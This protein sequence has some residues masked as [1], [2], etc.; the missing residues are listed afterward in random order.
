[1][2]VGTSQE[3]GRRIKL[4]LG[5]TITTGN[6]TILNEGIVNVNKTVGAATQITLPRKPEKEDVILIKD[7]KGDAGTNAITIL[8]DGT[9][10]TT[11]DGAASYL[12][13]AN[14]GSV[15]LGFNGTEWNALGSFKSGDGI[16][17]SAAGVA[18]HD[19][20]SEAV[21]ASYTIPANTIKAGTTITVRGRLT[22]TATVG[23]DT[24][25]FL[26]RLGTTTL[27]GTALITGAATNVADGDQAVFEF[28]LFGT[29]APGAAAAILGMGQY[30][31]PAGTVFKPATLAS[32][33]FATNG[34]L[35]LEANL[36]WSTAN[37]N[38]AIVDW[39]T[40]S[41]NNP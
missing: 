6:Y 40:V 38:S 28:T 5:K 35:K 13:N 16:V 15:F 23:T 18:V 33:N 21:S 29:A 39:M 7:A 41:I 8:P 11:I 34:A 32:T 22:A 17:K 36:K 9:E 24:L 27:T 4:R 30:T 3:T 20:A 1:M 26:L 2:G 25:Q 10:A 19:S 37:A 14:Y 12:L 31:E